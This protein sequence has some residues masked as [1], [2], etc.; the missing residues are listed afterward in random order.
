LHGKVLEE[1][2]D[3]IDIKEGIDIIDIKE[4]IDI[5]HVMIVRTAHHWEDEFFNNMFFIAK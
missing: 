1:G 5:I 4:G 2:I 3:I